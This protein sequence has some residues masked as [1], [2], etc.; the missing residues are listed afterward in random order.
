[1]YPVEL[2]YGGIDGSHHQVWQKILIET[3]RYHE[4]ECL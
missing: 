1:M 2:P 4:V 3:S